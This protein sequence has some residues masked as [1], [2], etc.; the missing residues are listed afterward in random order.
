MKLWDKLQS[1]PA[2]RVRHSALRQ[3]RARKVVSF[4]GCCGEYSGCGECAD[5]FRAEDVCLTVVRCACGH[6]LQL[7]QDT[8]PLSLLDVERAPHTYMLFLNFFTLSTQ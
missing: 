6:R 1:R 5:A 7:F 2:A 3:L 8:A 4:D